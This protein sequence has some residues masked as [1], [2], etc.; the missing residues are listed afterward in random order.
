MI[1]FNVRIAWLKSRDSR[2][3]ILF[4]Q[5]EWFRKKLR[6]PAKK[7]IQDKFRLNIRKRVSCKSSSDPPSQKGTISL[8]ENCH[9]MRRKTKEKKRKMTQFGTDYWVLDI[10]FSSSFNFKDIGTWK[11]NEKNIQSV[12]LIKVKEIVIAIDMIQEYPE[13]S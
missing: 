13:R 7:P 9:E 10:E 4:N 6:Q 2:L 11:R 3:E 1:G 12:E 5:F 8:W